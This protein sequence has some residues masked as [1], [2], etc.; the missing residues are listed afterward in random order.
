MT[1]IKVNYRG[2][3]REI[4]EWPSSMDNFRDQCYQKFAE[5]RLFDNASSRWSELNSDPSKLSSF[6][7]QSIAS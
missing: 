7:S 6:L 4:E 3:I 1:S 2:K 5:W